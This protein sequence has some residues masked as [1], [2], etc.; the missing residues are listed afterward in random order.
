MFSYL[1]VDIKTSLS[2]LT[3]ATVLKRLYVDLATAGNIYH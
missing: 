3:S 2:D 1:G